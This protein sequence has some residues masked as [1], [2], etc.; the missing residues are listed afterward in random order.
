MHLLLKAFRN[1]KQHFSS[2][3]R[4]IFKNEITNKKTYRNAKTTTDLKE[5]TGCSVRA[6]TGR[7]SIALFDF[8][9]KHTCLA[10]QSFHGSVPGYVH[11]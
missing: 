6:E 2:P 1:T 3:L 7:Q 4:G 8:N 11:K 5:D 10:T 9:R